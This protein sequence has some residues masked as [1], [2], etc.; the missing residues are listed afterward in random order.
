MNNDELARLAKR[1]L[2]PKPTLDAFKEEC[3]SVIEETIVE[4]NSVNVEHI[5]GSLNDRLQEIILSDPLVY[6][7][8]ATLVPPLVMCGGH[9]I[10]VYLITKDGHKY[11]HK[12]NYY[13]HPRS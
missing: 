8:S 5:E 7:A 3:Q 2:A 12:L 10:V 6:R 11:M 1:L 13:V 4:D 9:A